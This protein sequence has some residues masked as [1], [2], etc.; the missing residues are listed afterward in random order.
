MILNCFGSPVL[1]RQ[2]ILLSKTLYL[3]CY[4]DRALYLI[5]GIVEET[6]QILSNINGFKAK[7]L[8]K[9]DRENY[10]VR[11]NKKMEFLRVKLANFQFN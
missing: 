7:I 8:I 11:T 4:Q 10:V 9:Y 5:Y 6:M 1:K 3:V 2:L